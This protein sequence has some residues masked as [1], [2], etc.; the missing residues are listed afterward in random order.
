[1]DSLSCGCKGRG[2]HNNLENG[3]GYSVPSMLESGRYQATAG[4]HEKEINQHNYQ[5]VRQKSSL[6]PGCSLPGPLGG[7]GFAP[8]GAP[9]LRAPAVSS[10]VIV[11]PLPPSYNLQPRQNNSQKVEELEKSPAVEEP[12]YMEIK[13]KIDKE[14]EMEE[15]QEKMQEK[16]RNCLEEVGV[17]GGRRKEVEYWQITAKEVVKFRP[18]TETFINRS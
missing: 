2:T 10:S 18:C 13:P 1:M 8:R 4:L 3:R 7:R 16:V 14:E 6:Q 11:N 9:D 17:K 5:A 15:K 12:I